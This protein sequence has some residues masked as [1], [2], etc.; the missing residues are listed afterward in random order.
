[1]VFAI[2]AFDATTPGTLDRRKAVRAQHLALLEHLQSEGKFQY[3]GALLNEAGDMVGSMIII[4]VPTRQ[5]LQSEYLDQEP[6]IHH[7]VWDRITIN[8]FSL[9]PLLQ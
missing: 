8:G 2:M 9:S 5:A 1:M 7:A 3:G 4:N 6:Y